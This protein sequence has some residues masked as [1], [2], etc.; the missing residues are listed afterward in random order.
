MNT[1][2]N[3]AARRIF[4]RLDKDISTRRGLGNE[5]DQISPNIKNVELR[6]AWEQIFTEEIERYESAEKPE[7]PQSSTLLNQHDEILL[8]HAGC[9]GAL[10]EGDAELTQTVGAM[11]K[12]ICTLSGTLAIA[13]DRLDLQADQIFDLRKNNDKLT[14]RLNAIEGLGI[15][16]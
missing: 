14:S 1:N 8:D 10:Q 2:L 16:R 12:T 5:W 7:Q 4:N 15:P 3:V 11:S 9:I 13:I 6:S